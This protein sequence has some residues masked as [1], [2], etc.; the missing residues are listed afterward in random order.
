M[1]KRRTSHLAHWCEAH[2]PSLHGENGTHSTVQPGGRGWPLQ[3]ALISSKTSGIPPAQKGYNQTLSIL[4]LSKAYPTMGILSPLSRHA[5][6]FGSGVCLAGKLLTLD[7]YFQYFSSNCVDSY[8]LGL[9][10]SLKHT[11][12]IILSFQEHQ[13]K[14][15]FSL[16][17]FQSLLRCDALTKALI[18]ASHGESIRF[19]L[20]RWT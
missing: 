20:A 18:S 17:A 14:F 3:D 1:T 9:P 5:K 13:H 8:K 11:W 16:S 6:L 7:P 19:N 12:L 10:N 4:I 2:L 15:I